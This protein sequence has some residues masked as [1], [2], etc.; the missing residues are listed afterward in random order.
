MIPFMCNSGIGKLKIRIVVS[1]GG[2]RLTGKEHRF[3]E[4]KKCSIS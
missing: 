2:K 4:K 1:A 3:S